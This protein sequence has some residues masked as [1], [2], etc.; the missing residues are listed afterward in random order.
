MEKILRIE[1]RFPA[2]FPPVTSQEVEAE[3]QALHEAM[4]SQDGEMCTC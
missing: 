3:L 2:F 4:S 1:P